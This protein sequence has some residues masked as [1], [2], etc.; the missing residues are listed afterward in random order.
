MRMTTPTIDCADSQHAKEALSTWYDRGS[1]AS[2]AHVQGPLRFG[3]RERA[4]V[5]KVLRD[6][7]AASNDEPEILY[8]VA[9]PRHVNIVN[10][11][12]QPG[13]ASATE[14]NRKVTV[15]IIQ[16]NWQSTIR[17]DDGRP[18]I[19]VFDVQE[20]WDAHFC[21]AMVELSYFVKSWCQDWQA[22][23]RIVWLSSAPWDPL[24]SRIMSISHG[25]GDGVSMMRMRLSGARESFDNL[26]WTV[27]KE[28]CAD[29]SQLQ[30]IASNILADHLALPPGDRR[31][32]VVTV[33]IPKEE[34]TSAITAIAADA[35]EMSGIV[36]KQ[37]PSTYDINS[38]RWEAEFPP[39]RHLVLGG[40]MNVDAWHPSYNQVIAVDRVLST[41]AI[42]LLAA[43]AYADGVD[44]TKVTLHTSV[45]PGRLHLAEQP[46]RF[47]ETQLA[48]VIA[49]SFAKLPRADIDVLKSVLCTDVQRWETA[50]HW[51]RLARF[52]EPSDS[53]PGGFAMAS[54]GRAS[55][56]ATWLFVVDYD[57]SLAH[58]LAANDDRTPLESF[59]AILDIGSI[60]LSIKRVNEGLVKYDSRRHSEQMDRGIRPATI[61]DVMDRECSDIP[62]G[63]SATGSM[64]MMLGLYRRVLR[65]LKQGTLMPG[66]RFW[67]PE[68]ELFTVNI[69]VL[70]HA[71]RIGSGFRQMYE[72]LGITPRTDGTRPSRLTQDDVDF[73]RTAMVEGWA[74]RHVLADYRNT[75]PDGRPFMF[76]PWTGGVYRHNLS[77][78]TGF[79]PGESFST[80]SDGKAFII[81]TSSV[82]NQGD[83]LLKH[84][85]WIP[86][87]IVNEWMVGRDLQ[88]DDL[89]PP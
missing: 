14:T 51:L 13:H 39:L 31:S 46:R 84:P 89:W 48:S 70:M 11:Q 5:V 61:A 54:T 74:H 4:D 40:E 19:L 36:I 32:A 29:E 64:W 15:D 71:Q 60:L 30:L 67:N 56:T 10:E 50:F 24:I 79:F 12:L 42:R 18:A 52:I 45:P 44:P 38:M 8:V 34:L 76:S 86:S 81:G 7:A 80:D 41:A 69:G 27:Y 25:E 28:S 85:T 20:E 17:E 21:I 75:L 49:A 57:F 3:P 58:F 77:K 1:D 88:L 59:D 65:K 87:W 68:N 63:I 35:E 26:R 53:H 43:M 37:V 82:I 72:R 16:S 47:E 23:L 73:V 2:F 78:G 22:K 33:V 6:K 62:P 9:S 55:R 83:V 66:N